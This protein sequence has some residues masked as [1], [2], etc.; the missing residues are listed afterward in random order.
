MVQKPKDKLL[1]NIDGQA[2]LGLK[3][4]ENITHIVLLVIEGDQKQITHQ[5]KHATWTTGIS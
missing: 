4:I 2:I 1:F 5:I 3:I